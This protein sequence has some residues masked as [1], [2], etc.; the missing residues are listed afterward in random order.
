VRNILHNITQ[1]SYIASPRQILRCFGD[2]WCLE[3]FFVFFVFCWLSVR[4]LDVRLIVRVNPNYLLDGWRWVEVS[5][6][7]IVLN[8]DKDKG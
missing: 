8:T 1:A 7:K 3:V 2:V 4:I 5:K 6:K